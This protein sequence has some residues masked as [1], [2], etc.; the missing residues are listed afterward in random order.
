MKRCNFQHPSI[1][2]GCLHAVRQGCRKLGTAARLRHQSVPACSARP[3][4]EA[5]AHTARRQEGAGRTGHGGRLLPA[6]L[7]GRGGEEAEGF[8]DQAAALPQAPR[9]I[10]EGLELRGHAAVPA[11]QAMLRG[12]SPQHTFHATVPATYALVSKESFS[13]SGMSTAVVARCPLTG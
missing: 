9:R 6:A 8:P 13:C 12:C 1:T 5:P 10:P 11:R 4:R 2:Q 7:G 3:V